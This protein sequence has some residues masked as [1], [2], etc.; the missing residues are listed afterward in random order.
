MTGVKAGKPGE[1]AD[2]IKKFPESIGGKYNSLKK[3]HER[4]S[5]PNRLHSVGMPQFDILSNIVDNVTKKYNHLMNN[6]KN[7]VLH[8]RLGDAFLPFAMNIG[9]APFT[10]SVVINYIL[11]VVPSDYCIDIVNLGNNHQCSGNPGDTKTNTYIK[12]VVESLKSK[13]SKINI[14]NT[15][16]PDIDF[17]RMINADMFVQGGISGFGN[18]ARAVRE[19]KGLDTKCIPSTSERVK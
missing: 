8:L 15:S 14:L 19:Y 11:S 7:C 5:D 3:I 13:Y 6:K 18:A 17:C 1:T 12:N 2:A 10:E 16:H 9:Y 4:N